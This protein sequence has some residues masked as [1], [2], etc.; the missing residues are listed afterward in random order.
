M[1]YCYKHVQILRGNSFKFHTNDMCGSKRLPGCI[2]PYIGDK[3]ATTCIWEISYK[4]WASKIKHQVVSIL[5]IDEE[6]AEEEEGK[7]R[8]TLL[9]QILVFWL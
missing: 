3:I 9:C 4:K 7:K 5:N 6:V 8:A 1:I 2:Q